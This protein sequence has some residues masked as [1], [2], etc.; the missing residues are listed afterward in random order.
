MHILN[1]LFKRKQIEKEVILADHPAKEIE[2]AEKWKAV[3]KYI[4]AEPE[5][6]ELVSVIAT[7][8][9]A[10]D[11]PESRFAVKKIKQINPEA[12]LVSTVAVSL[13]TGD[14]EHSQFAVKKIAKK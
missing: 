5:A 14:S 8:I 13:A 9:A 11:M 6:Y 10:G 12:A 1:R 2:P 4:P 7:A 3:P